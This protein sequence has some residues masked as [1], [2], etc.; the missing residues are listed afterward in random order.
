MSLVRRRF[1]RWLES[2][3]SA[4][5]YFLSEVNGGTGEREAI[6]S[7]NRGYGTSHTTGDIRRW[8]REDPEFAKA[9]RVARSEPPSSPHCWDL[10]KYA[11]AP[12]GPP[13]PPGTPDSVAEAAGWVRLR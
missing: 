5:E 7:M 2:D 12:T 1:S 9:L 13:P 11:D 6:E 3:D 4:K 10:S 8:L